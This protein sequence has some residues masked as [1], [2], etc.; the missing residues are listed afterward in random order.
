VLKGGSH[1]WCVEGGGNAPFCEKKKKEKEGT[2]S[3]LGRKEK[4]GGRSLNVS[5]SQGKKNL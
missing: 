5:Q 3:S 1:H 4:E 2:A